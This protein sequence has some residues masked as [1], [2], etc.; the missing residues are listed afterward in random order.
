MPPPLL[1]PPALMVTLETG[2]FKCYLPLIYLKMSSVICE[3]FLTITF[4][5]WKKWKCLVNSLIT[6]WLVEIV[7]LVH[8]CFHIAFQHIQPICTQIW[9]LYN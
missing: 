9:S 2:Q 6:S 4:L 5:Y 7:F 8:F 3:I 1:M